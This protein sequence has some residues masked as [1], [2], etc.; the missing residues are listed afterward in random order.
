MLTGGMA[1]AIIGFASGRFSLGPIAVPVGVGIDVKTGVPI[2]TSVFTGSLGSVV[3]MFSYRP[4]FREFSKCSTH[5]SL[6]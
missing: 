4:V 1:A 2:V 5:M 6:L 3:R